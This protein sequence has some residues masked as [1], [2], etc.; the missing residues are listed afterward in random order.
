[1]LPTSENLQQDLS[2]L[3]TLQLRQVA[4]FIAFIKFRDQHPKR[5]IDP[6]QLAQLAEF[7]DDD[8]AMAEAGID[9]YQTLLAQED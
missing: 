1:M 2:T 9:D 3:T 7:A 4:D 6:A 8:Q 5:T